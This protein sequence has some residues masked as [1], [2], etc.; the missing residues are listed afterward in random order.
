[1]KLPR[2]LPDNQQVAHCLQEAAQHLEEQGAN[3]FRVGAYLAAADTVANLDA[4]IRALFDEGGIDALDALPRIG[5]GIAGAI[6]E[7][8]ITD[9]WRQLERLRGG[10][11]DAGLFQTVPGIGH[12]LATRIRDTLHI[13]TLEAL[14]L[15]ARDGRLE[16]VEG[17]GPRRLAG[18]RAA[19][20]E[21]LSR[22]RQWRVLH[23][24]KAPLMEPSVSMLLEIDRVYREKAAAGALP[25]I[26]PKRLNPEGKAWL[27]VL[28]VTKDQWHFTALFSNTQRAHELRRTADW[29]VIYFYDAGHEEGQRTVVT[30][31][32]G[33]LIGSRVVRGRELE[34]REQYL[35]RAP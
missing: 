16:R 9:R 34:C 31:T 24:R 26:A 18:I 15:A 22:Q 32:R 12:E 10:E 3:P 6:A 19:L 14:E 1:M 28:H 11:D 27:P 30:E 29:V 23:Q 13:D 33:S 21:I 4:D 2:N 35:E 20:D 7:M 8:L 25:T 17:V 5:K